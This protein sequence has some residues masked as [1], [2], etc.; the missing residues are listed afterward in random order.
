MWSLVFMKFLNYVTE[1]LIFKTVYT[2]L[3]QDDKNLEQNFYTKG[4]FPMGIYQSSDFMLTSHKDRLLVES[5]FVQ[6]VF[7]IL[8]V[9]SKNVVFIFIKKRSLEFLLFQTRFSIFAGLL[10]HLSSITL[11]NTLAFSWRENKIG[12]IL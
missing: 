4:L 10:H 7:L 8:H 11:Q 6:M 2:F 12:F 1:V 5:C 9:L 3:S